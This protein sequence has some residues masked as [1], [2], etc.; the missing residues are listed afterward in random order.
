VVVRRRLAAELADR[1]QG[2]EAARWRSRAVEM[3][4][5]KPELSYTLALFYARQAGLTGQVP[6]K[7]NDRQ[8]DQRRRWFAAGAVAMLRQAVAD[9]LHDAARLRDESLFE[10]LR[11]DP[12]FRAI[13]ADLEF[14]AEPFAKS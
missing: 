11:S 14:P 3:V 1:G 10:P 8:L 12:G 5:G 13:L 6:T 2:G 4:R 7:L 9:G